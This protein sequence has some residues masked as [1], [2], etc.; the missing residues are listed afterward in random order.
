MNPSYELGLATG[1]V[2]P[3]AHQVGE[4]GLV[5]TCGLPETCQLRLKEETGGTMFK[6]LM[7]KVFICQRLILQRPRYLRVSESTPVA[8]SR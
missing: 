3:L 6:A 4:P 8:C 2:R 7:P 1:L 5:S